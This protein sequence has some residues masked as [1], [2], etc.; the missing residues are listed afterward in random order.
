MKGFFQWFIDHKTP[1][2]GLAATLILFLMLIPLFEFIIMPLI[3]NKGA[4]R[5]L[6]DVTEIH[7]QEGKKLL[8]KKGFQIVID[9]TQHDA[10]YPESTVI[11]QDPE[12]FTKVKR[13]RRIY[14]T[15]SRGERL[16]MVPKV[17][18]RSE[19]DAG[20]DLKQAGLKLGEVFYEYDDYYYEGIVSNQQIVPET[21]V[22]ADT[23]VDITVSNGRLPTRFVVPDVVGK[24]LN[25]AKRLL[26]QAGLQ[27]GNI[28][29][30]TK[31][32]LI[33]ETVIAQSIDPEEEVNRGTKIRLI[34][35]RLDEEF[36]P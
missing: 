14:V 31:E 33:P 10:T 11:Y 7:F 20:F 19:R 1:L 3:T 12:P 6:P 18:G 30:E 28:V 15:L 22:T 17:I 13:G 9:H 23:P 29:F 21:E 35:S 8:E 24:S 27:V 5:E 16:V 25:S 36:R 32:N 26:R 34:V 2:L 4:E